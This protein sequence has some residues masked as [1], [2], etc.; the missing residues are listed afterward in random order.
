MNVAVGL[1]PDVSQ[2]R[3][4]VVVPSLSVCLRDWKWQYVTSLFHSVS[5]VERVV[6]DEAERA[7]K[8][9]AA[10]LGISP[11][12][13]AVVLEDPVPA[14]RA[15]CNDWHIAM[16][17]VGTRRNAKEGIDPFLQGILSEVGC[18]VMTLQI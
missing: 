16:L 6:R 1:F 8:S 13:V 15:Y 10:R 12:G 7:L 11:E 9:R 17:V 3:V 4:L 18:D 2:A 14:I 5:E